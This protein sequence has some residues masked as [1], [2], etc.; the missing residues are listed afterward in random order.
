[1]RRDILKGLEPLGIKLDME[2]NDVNFGE[3]QV[4]S[5]ADSKVTVAVIGTDEELLIASDTEKLVK[6]DC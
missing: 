3:N 4:I 2:K 6:G 1:V 5:S